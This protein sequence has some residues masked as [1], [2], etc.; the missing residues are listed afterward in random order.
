MADDAY[1]RWA[2]CPPDFDPAAALREPLQW[3]DLAPWPA[4]GVAALRR[5]WQLGPTRELAR[6]WAC[7]MVRLPSQWKRAPAGGAERCPVAYIV[8]E[9]FTMLAHA[10]GDVAQ[11]VA[12]EMAA[13]GLLLPSSRRCAV[14]LARIPVDR[15]RQVYV[16][17]AELG[18]I[19][20]AGLAHAP[21]V[22]QALSALLRVRFAAWFAQ[23]PP[24]PLVP[25]PEYL[26]PMPEAVPRGARPRRARPT[27][28]AASLGRGPRQRAAPVPPVQPGLFSE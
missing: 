22:V 1:Q 4:D 27:Q 12:F 18:L 6:V 17:R 9:C 25:A 11:R 15:L 3:L 26:Q 19:D 13:R 2:Q 10:G 23:H 24:H 20:P 7:G 21:A 14:G 16:L 28:P 5:G 8:P